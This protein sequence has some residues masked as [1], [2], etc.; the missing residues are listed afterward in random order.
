MRSVEGCSS[1][2]SLGLCRGQAAL[3]LLLGARPTPK[4]LL[5]QLQSSLLYQSPTTCTIHSKSLFNCCCSIAAATFLQCKVL[6]SCTLGL[7][8]HGWIMIRESCTNGGR[9]SCCCCCFIHYL[10]I[11]PPSSVICALHVLECS[12]A[13]LCMT[14]MQCRRHSK[15]QVD[16]A[17]VK[18]LVTA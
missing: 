16:I 15:Q 7:A 8:S 18:S 5:S 17:I 12:K 13:R 11:I 2:T 6:L 9:S 4:L 3:F 10:C 14:R 1:E